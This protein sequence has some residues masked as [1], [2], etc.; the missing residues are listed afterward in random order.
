[1]MF[2]LASLAAILSSALISVD[3]AAGVYNYDETHIWDQVEPLATN[4]CGGS[5]NSPIAVTDEGCTDYHNYVM[6]VSS[7]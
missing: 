4:E 1:M 5:S 7:K 2:R 3:A 6:V